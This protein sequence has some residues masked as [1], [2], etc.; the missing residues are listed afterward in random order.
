M[1]SFDSSLGLLTCNTL[2]RLDLLPFPV[3]HGTPACFQKSL[4]LGFLWIS[5]LMTLAFSVLHLP[6][7]AALP[8]SSLGTT[9]DTL[10][11]VSAHLH[12]QYP[13][14]ADTLP[15]HGAQ[16]VFLKSYMLELF[17]FY[18]FFFFPQ[19]V[20]WVLFL[21]FSVGLHLYS[22]NEWIHSISF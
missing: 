14:A 5:L 3:A 1:L 12:S 19:S 7:E 17:L 11:F 10:D 13:G 2:S 6:T 9:S 8:N 20:L 16:L 18:F 15:L 21:F 22:L 4:C